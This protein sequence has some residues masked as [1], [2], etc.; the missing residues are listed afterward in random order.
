MEEVTGEIIE[1][2]GL[3]RGAAGGRREVD[4]SQEGGPK[5]RCRGRRKMA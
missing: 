3:G 5:G 4:I 2:M 1:M